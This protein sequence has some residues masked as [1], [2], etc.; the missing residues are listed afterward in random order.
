[1]AEIVDGFVFGRRPH[2]TK[3][4]WDKFLDGRCWKLKQGVDFDCTLQS[5][6]RNAANVATRR[7][8]SLKTQRLSDTVVVIQASNAH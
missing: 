4:D 3:Y 8:L 2:E 5:F 1:M 7:G 6:R